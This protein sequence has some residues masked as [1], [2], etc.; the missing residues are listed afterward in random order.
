M[1]TA[2]QILEKELNVLKVAYETANK[3]KSQLLNSLR[4]EMDITKQDEFAEKYNTYSAESLELNS[5]ISNIE[6]AIFYIK[7]VV[8][9]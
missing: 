1:K 6:Q 5:S 9:A 2:L 7:R 3:A 8:N 4:A